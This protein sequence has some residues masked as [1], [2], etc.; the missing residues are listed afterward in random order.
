M[1]FLDR[2]L[3]RRA[4]PVRRLVVLDAAV[5][6]A[7]AGLVLLQAVLIARVVAQAFAGATTRAMRTA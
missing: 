6:I 1:R 7:C 4:A 5:G 2:R 3:V